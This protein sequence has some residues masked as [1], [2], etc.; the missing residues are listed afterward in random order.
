MLSGVAMG[1]GSSSGG[2]THDQME[3]LVRLAFGATPVAIAIY[4]CSPG[5]GFLLGSPESPWG[6][7]SQEAPHMT[8]WSYL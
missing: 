2:T 5:G 8:R 7:R 3:L 6:R 1:G 4:K